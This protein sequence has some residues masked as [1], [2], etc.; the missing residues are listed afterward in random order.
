MGNGRGGRG[1]GDWYDLEKSGTQGVIGALGKAGFKCQDVQPVL[2]W[3]W[4][5]HNC[6]GRVSHLSDYLTKSCIGCL[7]VAGLQW[8]ELVCNCALKCMAC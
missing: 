8:G 5:G 1:S 4:V 3:A 2:C 6:M 7:E